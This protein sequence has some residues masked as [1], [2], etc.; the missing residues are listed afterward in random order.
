MKKILTTLAFFGLFS[1]Q[2]NNSYAQDIDTKK[3]RFGAFVAPT[4]SWMKPTANKSDDNSFLTSSDGSKIG[5]TYGLMAEYRFADNYSFVTGLQINMSGGKIN[6]ERALAPS[7][8]SKYIMNTAFDYNLQYIEIPLGLKMR[9]NLI[10]GFRFFGQLGVTPSFVISK[11][12]S[13]DVKAF[14][15]GAIQT[16]NDE[17]VKLKGAITISPILFQMNIGIGAEYPLSDQLCGYFG[18]FFNNGFAPDVTNTSK[19]SGFGFNSTFKDG[20]VRLNN[21]ALRLGLFF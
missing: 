15:D 20:N 10:E 1:A 9:T 16:F 18:L 17:N 8:S 19:Y 6:T 13:Y 3:L 11:K 4:V 14:Q 21:F 7:D 2:F 5:F 12:V